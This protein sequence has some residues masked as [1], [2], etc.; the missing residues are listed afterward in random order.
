PAALAL[1]FDLLLAF[2]PAAAALAGLLYFAVVPFQRVNLTW[3]SC[4]QDLLALLFALAALALFRRRRDGW[5][6]LAYLLAVFSKESALPLPLMLALWLRWETPVAQRAD[7][8]RRL[9]P[10][11]AV[12]ILWAAVESIMRARHP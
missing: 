9:V 5:A 1:L 7:A 11:V 10:F 12:T 3:V 4:S 2:L 6:V 8:R